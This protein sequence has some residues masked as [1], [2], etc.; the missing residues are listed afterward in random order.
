MKV[1]NLFIIEGEKSKRKF[2]YLLGK[3]NMKE[4]STI[5]NFKSVFLREVLSTNFSVLNINL[6]LSYQ[7][8]LFTFYYE[9]LLRKTKLSVEIRGL[10]SSAAVHKLL[11][12]T[13]KRFSKKD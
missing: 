5:K 2:G 4:S 10:E 8:F 12:I 11:L 9:H 3:R 7:D 1:H 13:L 6:L